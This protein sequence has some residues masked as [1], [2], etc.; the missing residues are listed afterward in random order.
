MF[1]SWSQSAVVGKLLSGF[2]DTRRKISDIAV[3]AAA[4]SGLVWL[5]FWPSARPL[6]MTSADGLPCLT[7]VIVLAWSAIHVD[8]VN[9]F[10]V[11]GLIGN[12]VTYPG[13]SGPMPSVSR[14]HPS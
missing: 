4:S 1:T 7:A 11:D 14:K 12:P 6:A 9:A 13:S 8:D 3:C 10:F 2:F 5:N